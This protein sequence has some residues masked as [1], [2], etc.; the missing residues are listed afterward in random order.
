[1]SK[2]ITMFAS[3]GIILQHV[4]H[5]T[6]LLLQPLHHLPPQLSARRQTR[7]ISTNCGLALPKAPRQPLAVSAQNLFSWLPCVLCGRPDRSLLVDCAFHSTKVLHGFLGTAMLTALT[8]HHKD[9]MQ[10]FRSS[11]RCPFHQPHICKAAPPTN[12]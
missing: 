9:D 8:C 2:P 5:I 11:T 3:M 7:V 4:T 6:P 1:M 12:A 10:H